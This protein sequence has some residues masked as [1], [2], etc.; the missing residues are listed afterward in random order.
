MVIRQRANGVY[1]W[2]I[3][4]LFKNP[5]TRRRAADLDAAAYISAAGVNPAVLFQVAEV[6][7]VFFLPDT[8]PHTAAAGAASPAWPRL[9]SSWQGHDGPAGARRTLAR[10]RARRTSTQGF[11]VY[12]GR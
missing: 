3:I 1:F 12:R 6:R 7:C 4:T 9:A 8:S 11:L 2:L 10:A 5:E